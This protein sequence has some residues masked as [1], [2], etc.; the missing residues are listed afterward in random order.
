MGAIHTAEYQK[1]AKY[2]AIC[3]FCIFV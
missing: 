1:S 3:A 2:R